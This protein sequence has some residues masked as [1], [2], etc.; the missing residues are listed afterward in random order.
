MKNRE[1]L[2]W[3]YQRI[4]L[5]FPLVL[6]ISLTTALSAVSGVAIALITKRVF[7]A[8]TSE[9]GGSLFFGGG[10]AFRGYNFSG[11]A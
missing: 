10:A 4:K 8:A 6:L 5:Y 11:A 7:D 2:K 1:T 3:I 9:G